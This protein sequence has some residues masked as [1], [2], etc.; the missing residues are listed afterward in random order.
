VYKKTVVYRGIGGNAFK[1]EPEGVADGIKKVESVPFSHPVLTGKPKTSGGKGFRPIR[2]PCDSLY[3]PPGGAPQSRGGTMSIPLLTF[4]TPLAPRCFS[5][6]FA[7]SDL[8]TPSGPHL[9]P[10]G[11]PCFLRQSAPLSQGSVFAIC[12]QFAA[13]TLVY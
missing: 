8:S 9:S 10:L 4:F 13:W 3:R 5:R 2:W 1:P 11:F 7:P 6:V 12:D